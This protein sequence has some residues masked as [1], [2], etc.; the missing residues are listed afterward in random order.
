MS[1]KIQQEITVKVTVVVDADDW[2]ADYGLDTDN[3]A[4]I[5]TDAKDGMTG[6]VEQVLRDLN[7]G[8]QLSYKIKDATA[9]LTSSLVLDA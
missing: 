9:T 5:E 2:A 6:N 8:G 3:L 4:E 1:R 7:Q